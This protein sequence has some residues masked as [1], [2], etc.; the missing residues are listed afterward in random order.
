[1]GMTQTRLDSTIESKR[2]RKK[3]LYLVT[4][5]QWGGVQKYVYDLA[6]GLNKN[7]Y[8]IEIGIGEGA[9]GKWIEVLKSR[10]F[11]I[12]ALK[13]VIREINLWHDFLSAFELYR[14]FVKSKPDIIHLNSSKIGATGAVVAWIY[15]KIHQEAAGLKIIYSVHGF[16][17]TEP[18]SIFRRKFYLWS[19]RISGLFKDKII[20]VSEHDKII[21]LNN[22]IAHYKKFVTVHNGVN[23]NKLNFLEKNKARDKLSTDYQLPKANHWIGTIA[24]LYSTKGLEYLIRAAK[25]LT[26]KYSDLIFIVIGE[27]LSRKQLEK[28]IR[29]FSLENKFFLPGTIPKAFQYLKTLD[30][31]CLSSLKEGFPYTLIEALAAGLPIVATQVGGVMEIVETDTNG[32]VVPPK[33]PRSLAKAIEKIINDENLRNK[34]KN[35]NLAKTKKFSLEKM[36]RE[37]EKMYLM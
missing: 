34:F 12:W 16:V 3:I 13:H 1:M 22:H 15:K 6:N 20:C 24:N 10:G 23:L 28:E 31:F 14:L 2:E 29:K 36:I 19:E 17:F 35:N 9:Q 32:L 21:G 27:G 25:I 18:L 5:S 30:I 8:I 4:Q 11:K 7:K 33:K 26:D 37:T